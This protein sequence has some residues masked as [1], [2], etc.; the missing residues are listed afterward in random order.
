MHQYMKGK[1]HHRHTSIKPAKILE[2]SFRN[3]LTS[4][5]YTYTMYIM[6]SALF[7][8]SWFFCQSENGIRFPY[9][10]GNMLKLLWLDCKT[11]FPSSLLGRLGL[12]NQTLYMHIICTLLYLLKFIIYFMEKTSFHIITFIMMWC[13]LSLIHQTAFSS[14]GLTTHIVLIGME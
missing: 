12:W 8:K 2:I 9:T 11:H 4:V 6:Q 10:K 7:P 13:G 3:F 1:P 5:L 14:Y